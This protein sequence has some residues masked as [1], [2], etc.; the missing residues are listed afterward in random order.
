MGH[1]VDGV[2]STAKPPVVLVNGPGQVFKQFGKRL[3]KRAEPIIDQ[4]VLRSFELYHSL[5]LDEEKVNLKLDDVEVNRFHRKIS[6]DRDV[7][8][9][10]S[11]Q[12]WL[13]THFRNRQ[14]KNSKYVM[15]IDM[16]LFALG[17]AIKT[18]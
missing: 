6:W 7:S 3:A 2:R 16:V 5:I 17:R 12:D 14:T 13:M 10:E 1:I 9:I 15:N 18:R 8:W 4:H 11:Y